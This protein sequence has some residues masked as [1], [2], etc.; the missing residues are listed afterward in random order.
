MRSH[1]YGKT[2]TAGRTR[3]DTPHPDLSVRA[4]S[5]KSVRTSHLVR[6]QL[7]IPGF[8]VDQDELAIVLSLHMRQDIAFVDLFAA[9]GEL[10]VAIPGLPHCVS[11]IASIRHTHLAL[12]YSPSARTGNSSAWRRSPV[13]GTR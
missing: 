12:I 9:P 2:E 1:P 6:V 4:A 10:F 3:A 8:D 11:H 5:E 7:V 13:M